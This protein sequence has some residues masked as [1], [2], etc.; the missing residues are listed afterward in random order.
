M[1]NEEGDPGKFAK[2][3]Q[4]NIFRILSKKDKEHWY[5]WA[6]EKLDEFSELNMS[7]WL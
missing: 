7:I 2:K 1:V 5:H 6:E 4:L 3:G